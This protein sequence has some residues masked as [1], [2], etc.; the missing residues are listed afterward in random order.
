MSIITLWK[1][2]IF[3]ID[4]ELYELILNFSKLWLALSVIP[5]FSHKRCLIVS[6]KLSSQS[7]SNIT[8]YLIPSN[9]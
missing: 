5:I 9:K 8:W 3:S 2:N 4:K 1:V 6:K 7:W